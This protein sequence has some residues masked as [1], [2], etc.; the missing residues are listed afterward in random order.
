MNPPLTIGRKTFAWGTR[1]YVMGILNI[2]PDSFSGD[3]LIATIP[4][5]TEDDRIMEKG[6]GEKEIEFALQ[7]AR[8]ALA[9]GRNRWAWTRSWGASCR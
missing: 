5:K 4:Q 1:T 8:R 2:T 9:P 6:I 7:M 3:G